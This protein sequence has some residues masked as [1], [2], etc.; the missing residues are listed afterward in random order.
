VSTEYGKAPPDRRSQLV[1][2][3]ISTIFAGPNSAKH[4]GSVLTEHPTETFRDRLLVN[5]L[6]AIACSQATP[7]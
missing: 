1:D 7:H 4:A 6:A 3:T 5:E 2:P